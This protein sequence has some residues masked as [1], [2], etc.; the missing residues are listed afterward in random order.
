MEND[1]PSNEQAA[2]DVD[3]LRRKLADHEAQLDEFARLA[4]RVR[5][6]INNPLTGL[7]GQ[8]Q[9]LLRDDLSEKAMHRVETIVELSTRIRDAAAELKVVPR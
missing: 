3:E 7:L 4:S 1:R 6:E 5:H 8:A 2:P 9:L